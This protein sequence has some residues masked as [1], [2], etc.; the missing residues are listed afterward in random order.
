MSEIHRP[1]EAQ[2]HLPERKLKHERPGIPP[3]QAAEADISRKHEIAATTTDAAELAY[4]AK[5]SSPIVRMGV[6]G[7]HSTSPDLL[8]TLANDQEEAVRH[9]IAY[10]QNTP[11]ATLLRL[12][13]DTS[14]LVRAEVAR[15]KNTPVSVLPHLA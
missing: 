6:S 2:P 7:N 13:W 12:M 5:H 9:S 3:D 8:T 10:N 15:N 11:V 4:L 1:I 14:H